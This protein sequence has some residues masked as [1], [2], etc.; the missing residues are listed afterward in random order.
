MTSQRDARRDKNGL[1]LRELYIGLESWDPKEPGTG[2]LPGSLKFQFWRLVNW[3]SQ[4]DLISAS[5][6]YLVR[7]GDLRMG[8]ARRRVNLHWPRLWG[9]RPEH[10]W[11]SQSPGVT[12]TA[13]LSGTHRCN[14]TA[15]YCATRQ[16]YLSGAT[17]RVPPARRRG[18]YH[19]RRNTPCMCDRHAPPTYGTTHGRATHSNRARFFIQ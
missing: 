8:G 7:G 5:V 3:E 19:H 4:Y 17:W 6:Q 13:I 1:Y 18:R 10:V 15:L 16:V 2:R 9:R 14:Y 11:I 12:T